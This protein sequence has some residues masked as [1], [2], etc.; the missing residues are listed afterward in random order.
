MTPSSCS[1]EGG[2]PSH[3]TTFNDIWRRAPETYLESSNQSVSRNKP[4]KVVS[5]ELIRSKSI[6]STSA[7][8]QT[9]GSHSTGSRPTGSDFHEDRPQSTATLAKRLRTLQLR[10]S[11]ASTIV[12]YD[13]T[14][15]HVG[16]NEKGNAVKTGGN[17]SEANSTGEEYNQSPFAE[18]PRYNPDLTKVDPT[19]I[20][21]ARSSKAHQLSPLETPSLRATLSALDS[22]NV[23]VKND[24]NRNSNEKS[25]LS[26]TWTS[27]AFTGA[28]LH[29]TCSLEYTEHMRD[30][31]H[32]RKSYV[33]D[34]RKDNSQNHHYHQQQQQITT[35]TITSTSKHSI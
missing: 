13:T 25:S 28:S 20:T 2:S 1:T 17:D 33:I 12:K 29:G 35:T 32:K 4:R 34:L 19:P 22:V 18:A 23:N 21:T 30:K 8:N 11:R 9:L 3:I 7:D 6:D 14:A 5:K 24:D 15:S 31:F 16:Q 27:S 10:F 26:K